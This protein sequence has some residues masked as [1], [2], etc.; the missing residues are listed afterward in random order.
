MSYDL[1]LKW[2]WGFNEASAADTEYDHITGKANDPSVLSRWRVMPTVGLRYAPTTW[3]QLYAHI[4][5]GYTWASI[6][7]AQL[8]GAGIGDKSTEDFLLGVEFGAKWKGLF[9]TGIRGDFSVSDRLHRVGIDNLTTSDDEDRYIYMKPD[10]VFF[11]ATLAF[12]SLIP[13]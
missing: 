11:T 8:G 5:P 9:S 1:G 6:D 4:M 12:L 10:S 2:N 3:V 7:D 13:E